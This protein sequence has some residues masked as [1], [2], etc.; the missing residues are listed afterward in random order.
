MF[1]QEVPLEYIPVFGREGAILPLGPAVQHTGELKPDLDI[2]QVWVFGTAQQGMQLP[3]LN[4]EVSSD[5]GLVNLPP[6]VNIIVK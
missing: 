4:V 5:G 3:G 2:E 1:E 6:D